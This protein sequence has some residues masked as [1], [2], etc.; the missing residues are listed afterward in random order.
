MLCGVDVGQGGSQRFRNVTAGI[1]T[2]KLAVLY[3]QL[4]ADELGV[5]RSTLRILFHEY[6][7]PDQATR[8]ANAPCVVS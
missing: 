6:L 7:K 8:L 2:S 5:R 3:T 4:R 1:V